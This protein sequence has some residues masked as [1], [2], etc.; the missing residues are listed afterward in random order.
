[1]RVFFVQ[2]RLARAARARR[3]PRRARSRARQAALERIGRQENVIG[4]FAVVRL[5]DGGSDE[6]QATTVGGWRVVLERCEVDLLTLALAAE[7]LSGGR[8]AE[9]LD[10]RR[11]LP[12]CSPAPRAASCR[13]PW[14]TRHKAREHSRV[15]GAQRRWPT[16]LGLALR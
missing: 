9:R 5:G 4:L 2:L 16:G 14:R 7:A 10:A 3:A 11:R 1:L 6:S 8:P 15:R 13:R 12:C